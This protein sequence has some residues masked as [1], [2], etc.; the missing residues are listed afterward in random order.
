MRYPKATFCSGERHMTVT[1]KALNSCRIS[2]AQDA[3]HC[4][5]W[6]ITLLKPGWSPELLESVLGSN[7]LLFAGILFSFSVCIR[8]LTILT[9]NKFLS[10]RESCIVSNVMIRHFQYE[11]IE[12]NLT[13]FREEFSSHTGS[14]RENRS[15]Q[16]QLLRLLHLFLL[17]SN[18]DIGRLFHQFF[19]C[20]HK[21][22]INFIP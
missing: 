20:K 12:E 13:V 2:P 9:E 8:P 17:H 11:T 14:L 16:R 1:K 10:S 19:F 18:K 7:V 22:V 15:N 5:N 6:C 21:S 3:I 4:I